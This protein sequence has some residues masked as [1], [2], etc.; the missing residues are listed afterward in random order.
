MTNDMGIRY[1]RSCIE[2][3]MPGLAAEKPG[4]LIVD[5][6]GS[7]FTLELLNYCHSIN[8]H[9]ILRPPHTTHILQGEDVVHFRDFKP[10]Y[11]QAK[12]LH[13]GRKAARGTFRLT[14]A[15]LLLCAKRPWEQAFDLRH[16]LSAWESI[17]DR[18]PALRSTSVLGPHEAE[19][20]EGGRCPQDGG[21][22]RA[23]HRE[24]HAGLLRRGWRGRGC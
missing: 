7:H 8:L 13:I 6:H 11:H 21:Q 14:T 12:M 3:S 20:E 4:L 18:A 16:C 1:I 9:I 17:L 5:G 10:A 24:G 19:G 2:P 22:P 15:D 23:P